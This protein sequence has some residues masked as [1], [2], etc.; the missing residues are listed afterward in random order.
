MIRKVRVLNF[1]EDT[2]VTEIINDLENE[3]DKF[4]GERDDE[5]V[6]DKLKR[7]VEMGTEEFLPENFNPAIGYLDV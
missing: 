3:I 1:H 4:K 7:M 2:Q 6:V 5:L